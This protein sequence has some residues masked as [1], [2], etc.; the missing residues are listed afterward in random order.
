M[1][2]EYNVVSDISLEHVVYSVNSRI[3][4][5]WQPLGGI[6]VVHTDLLDDAPSDDQTEGIIY[7]QAIG[8]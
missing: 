3:K 4:D 2:K 7:L 8:R 5:G 1:M 6:A